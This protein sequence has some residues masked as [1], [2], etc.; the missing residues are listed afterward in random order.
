[1]CV[2]KLPLRIRYSFVLWLLVSCSFWAKQTNIWSPSITWSLFTSHTAA[3][4]PS[5]HPLTVPVVTDWYFL[6][7]CSIAHMIQVGFDKL[8]EEVL[9]IVC[10]YKR[11]ANMKLLKCAQNQKQLFPWFHMTL[12]ESKHFN[13][14]FNQVSVSQQNWRKCVTSILPRL[15]RRQRYERVHVMVWKSGQD[16]STHQATWNR[17]RHAL[18]LTFT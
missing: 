12:N 2:V 16:S 13:S 3:C 8:R 18:A 9:Q 17:C 10:V 15:R 11:R 4:K 1:M 5:I 6:A 7:H 14:I